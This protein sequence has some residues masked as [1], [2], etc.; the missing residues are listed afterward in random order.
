[1]TDLPFLPD[2]PILA[3]RHSP[4]AGAPVPG[5]RARLDAAAPVLA[6]PVRRDARGTWWL[7]VLRFAGRFRPGLAATAAADEAVL[8]RLLT[9]R[10]VTIILPL[11]VVFAAALFAG[12]HAISDGG[13]SLE[14]V[15]W[16]R[17]NIDHVFTESPVFLLFAVVA[18][19][20][21]PALG[22]L[23]AVAYGALDLVA[24]L[25]HPYEL[26]PLP[27]ALLGR[28]AAI[29][30]LWLLVV[31]IPAFGRMMALSW[32]RV[33]RSRTVVVMLAAAVTGMSTWIWTQAAVVLIRP[34]FTWSDLHYLSTAAVM[35]VQQGG[36]V[37]AIA[38]GLAAGGRAFLAGPAG[39]LDARVSPAPRQPATGPVAMVRRLGV[40]ALLTV[41][42]GGLIDKPLDVVILYGALA[43]SG[44][45]AAWVSQRTPIGLLV[46][47]LPPV[48][49]YALG[50][51]LA[52]GVALALMAPLFAFGGPSEFFSVIVVV[53]I[54]IFLVELATMPRSAVADRPRSRVTT[55]GVAALLG[56]ILVAA[57]MAAPVGVLADNCS[58]L[59]DCWSA[60]LLAALAAGALPMAMALAKGPPPAPPAPPP[61]PPPPP[62]D[63]AADR[64][65]ER[66]NREASKKWWEGERQRQSRNPAFPDNPKLQGMKDRYIDKRIEYYS[67]PPPTISDDGRPI[68]R[69]AFPSSGA[70]TKA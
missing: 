63:P 65:R 18:G 10:A 40:A 25:R 11:A 70:G 58:G 43:G 15:D 45:L 27:F 22:A 39:L 31:E 69:Q 46:R 12:L 41:A 21:S 30:L 53:G 3:P 49:R 26:A 20:A 36:V 9:R 6:A 50:T 68:D 16:L 13:R 5:A 47:A 51:G 32:P 60:P 35:P 64:E 38:A 8:G 1:M 61:S 67:G 14:Q 37:F 56:L 17:L 54:G 59:G 2:E 34:P 66:R 23:F 44:P 52:F 4:A 55:L 48:A 42:L 33:A 57:V 28:L 7:A 24:S 29:W 62:H 19:A